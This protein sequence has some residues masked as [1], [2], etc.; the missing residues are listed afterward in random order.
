[1]LVPRQFNYDLLQY[2]NWIH[3][4]IVAPPLMSQLWP[5][6]GVSDATP[7]QINVQWNVPAT[8]PLVASATN[9]LG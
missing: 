4:N 2:R 9:P 5:L 7:E 8:S 3:Q 6:G 1:M